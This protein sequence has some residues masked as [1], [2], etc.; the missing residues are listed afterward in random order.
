MKNKTI[1]STKKGYFLAVLTIF[2]ATNTYFASKYILLRVNVFQFG[3]LWY[4]FALI[5][6]FFYQF[7]TKQLSV[8]Q[9]RRQQIFP[10]LIFLL[11]ELI[12]TTSFFYSIRQT[13]NPASVSF[14][15]NLTPVLVTI[16]G[17]LFL[18]EI[19]NKLELIGV[20]LAIVGSF[21]VSIHWPFRSN[22]LFIEGSEYVYVTVLASSINTIWVKK[23]IQHLHPSLLSIGRVF[24]LFIFSLV[25][26]KITHDSFSF[27]KIAVLLASYGALIGPL[28]GALLQ[29]Y[30]LIYIPASHLILI[31]SLKSF[32][33]LIVA[34]L[35]M[36][37]FPI[38]IQVLGGIFTVVGVFL[39]TYRK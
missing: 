33:I 19:F 28:F 39:I 11:L 25:A 30:A 38:Y 16:M 7:F 1:S 31:Q 3:I 15:S 5:Y 9:I 4:G 20:I 13:I 18:N 35:L 10:F 14:I 34:Y 22:N 8:Y 6:N 37:L 2:T 24:I 32:V 12:S 21:L 26:L 36:G 23:N 29:Y 27:D 17:V